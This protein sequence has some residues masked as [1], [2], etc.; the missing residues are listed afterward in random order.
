MNKFYEECDAEKHPEFRF[1]AERTEDGATI[2]YREQFS[3][4]HRYIWKYTYINGILR[5]Y[6]IVPIMIKMY[7]LVIST[8]GP[9]SGPKWR[10][11]FKT[12]F[13]TPLCYARNDPNKRICYI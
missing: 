13:S 10:N 5:N 6:T 9:Q 4:S 2:Y 7:A 11:L 1:L 8:E 12:D 3:C